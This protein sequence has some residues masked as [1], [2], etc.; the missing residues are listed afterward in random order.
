M[1]RVRPSKDKKKKKKK[2]CLLSRSEGRRFSLGWRWEGAQNG[3]LGG[4][5]SLLRDLPLP[6]IE[7]EALSEGT[8]QGSLDSGLKCISLGFSFFLKQVSLF[9]I[10]LHF[11]L[12]IS[13]F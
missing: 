6:P 7:P 8:G 4:L 10:P 11:V 3:D 12:N 2:S 1:L 9:S 13:S 5:V